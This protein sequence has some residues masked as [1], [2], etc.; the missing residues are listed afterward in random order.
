MRLCQEPRP[1]ARQANSCLTGGSVVRGPQGTR[2]QDTRP[3][4]CPAQALGRRWQRGPRTASQ[5]GG[6]LVSLCAHR[7]LQGG[8]GPGQMWD[9]PCWPVAAQREGRG[10]RTWGPPAGEGSWALGLTWGGGSCPGEPTAGGR[11]VA[12]EMGLLAHLFSGMLRGQGSGRPGT[13]AHLTP[14][15]G[16]VCSG[17]TRTCGVQAQ[18]GKPRAA[19][20]PARPGL[21][22]PPCPCI[23]G[24]LPAQAPQRLPC[25]PP[26]P[27]SASPRPGLHVCLTAAPPPGGC[28]PRTP[29]SLPVPSAPRPCWPPA[30]PPLIPSFLCRN[31]K[32]PSF[33]TLWT[34]SRYCPHPLGA[35]VGAG[36]RPLARE[37][38]GH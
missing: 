32:P 16:W 21:L 6:G 17:S 33:I 11:V 27:S 3:R 34:G 12:I 29:P 38:A 28:S 19:S 9:G 7:D 18:Q 23:P 25:P 2:S 30:A 20:Q 10:W 15:E 22:H 35:S 37:R 14:R 26:W 5:D 24:R 4:C 13:G 1:A 8:R 36:G 31:L